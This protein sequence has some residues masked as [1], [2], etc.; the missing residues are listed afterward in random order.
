M[1][2]LLC[3]V[4]KWQSYYEKKSKNYYFIFKLD[5]FYSLSFDSDRRVPERPHKNER[6]WASLS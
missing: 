1:F 5:V 3:L 6:Q 2:H 4:E